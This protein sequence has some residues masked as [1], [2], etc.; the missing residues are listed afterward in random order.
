[1]WMPSSHTWVSPLAERTSSVPT[2]VRMEATAGQNRYRVVIPPPR[3][4][5]PGGASRLDKRDLTTAAGNLV[6]TGTDETLGF[7]SLLLIPV[8]NERVLPNSHALVCLF[9]LPTNV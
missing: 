4:A 5:T 3:I 8:P 6:Y 7:P 1:M 2:M 9:N